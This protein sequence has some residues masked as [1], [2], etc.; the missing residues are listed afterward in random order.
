MPVIEFALDST[1]SYRIQ[2]HQPDEQPAPVTVLLNRSILGSLDPVEQNTGKDFRLP[3]N[4]VLNVRIANGLLQVSRNG[5]PLQPVDASTENIDLSPAAQAQLRSKKLG[6]CLITWLILNLVVIGS[7]TLL[8]F[9]AIF[10]ATTAGTSPLP[11]LLLGLT[12]IVG[13]VGISMIFFWKKVGF[14]LTVIYVVLDLVLSIPFGL[15]V[16]SFIP[17]IAVAI[18]YIYLNRSGIW[19]KMS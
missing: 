18:L 14:Y 11:F 8:Y 19:Q 13:L 4:S 1:A 5:L 3:D 16:R 15:D 10:G 12:G 7:L 17:L 2:V 9:L 6:G